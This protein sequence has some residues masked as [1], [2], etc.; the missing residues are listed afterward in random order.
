[1]IELKKAQEIVTKN[2]HPLEPRDTPLAE[3]VGLVLADDVTADA[4]LPP[5][6][7]SAMDGFAVRASDLSQVPAELKVIENIPA[8]YQPKKTIEA[9]ECSRI[10]TGAPLPGGADTVVMVED[11][12]PATDDRIRVLRAP[13]PKS[14]ICYRGEDVKRG[15]VVVKRGTIIRPVEVGLLAT[16]GVSLPRVHRRPRVAVLAT[17]DEVVEVNQ[18]PSPG[19]IRNSNSYSL[20]A[21]IRMLGIDAEYLGIASDHPDNLKVAIKKG[22][23]R[24]IFLISGGVSMGDYDLVPGIIKTL[25]VDIL[26][27]KVNVKPGKPT[28]FGKYEQRPVFGVPGNPVSS[29]VIT[30]LLVIPAI[31]AMMGWSQPLPE[32]MRATLAGPLSHKGDRPSYRPVFLKQEVDHWSASTGEYH[33]SADISG[34]SL[35][36]ALAKMPVDR[37]RMEIGEVVEV[38]PFGMNSFITA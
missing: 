27:E 37:K 33:G 8:G 25:G 2:L 21:R 1:M 19:Q 4:D 31:K 34:L 18:K 32:T 35:G 9:G 12:E 17:G 20:S 38:I 5:F 24:D 16:F 22:M 26:F 29:L 10:M 30:E 13:D 36:N 11:T 3:S 7:K 14:N 6:D 23:E 15:S 28:V